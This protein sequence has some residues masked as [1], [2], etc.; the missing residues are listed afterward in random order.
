MS[1]FWVG[2]YDGL[3]ADWTKDNL[4]AKRFLEYAG[5]DCYDV[6]PFVLD[7]DSVSCPIHDIQLL[8]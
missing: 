2:D 8:Q 5:F 6:E 3:Y 7:A 4:V 1:V